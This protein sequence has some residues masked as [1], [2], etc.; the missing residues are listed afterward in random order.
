MYSYFSKRL[1]L[2]YRMLRHCS[3]FSSFSFSQDRDFCLLH[4][5]DP[6]FLSFSGETLRYKG[7]EALY[8]FFINEC[9]FYET[10]VALSLAR[11]R[12]VEIPA[13]QCSRTWRTFSRKNVERYRDFSVRQTG[14]LKFFLHPWGF[15]VMPQPIN[16]PYW[17]PKHQNLYSNQNSSTNL[18]P[19]LLVPYPFPLNTTLNHDTPLI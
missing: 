12:K 4:P 8:P 6:V 18:N 15:L 13:V 9:S 1:C 16:T 3:D 5:G 11:R 10:G 19:Q 14:L 17:N 2:N 7:K